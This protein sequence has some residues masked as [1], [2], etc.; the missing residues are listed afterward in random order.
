[1][2]VITAATG[3]TGRIIATRLLEA[4][5]KVR[6]AGRDGQKLLPF[7]EKGA[8]AAVGSLEDP[9]FVQQ[10]F[11]GAKAVYTLI[12]PDFTQND[13]RAYQNKIGRILADAIAENRV[14]FVVNM[15]S[16]GADLSE[17]VGP[18][19]GLHDQEQ[20]LNQLRGINVLH[21]R[22]AY[23][24]ENLF[25]NIDLIKSQ[26][27]NGSPIEPDVAFPMIATR[28]IGE[29]AAKRLLQLDFRGAGVQELLGERDLTMPEATAAVGKAIGKPDLPYVRFPY[30]AAHEAM[31]NM[32]LPRGIAD[33]FVELYS[34]LNEGRALGPMK[35]TAE[36]TTPT[37]IEAF[38][39]IFAA[40]Y[41]A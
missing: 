12:P 33:M 18:V 23:F 13:F 26:G 10:A 21:L 24:M 29:Y 16:L 39:E 20:R 2:Y 15:S 35:R 30:Q 25:L 6:V 1:M 4:G 17:G 5:Q 9:G 27:V 8:E 7:V 14:E 37:S 3:N 31:I 22:P 19:N 32:G 41:H 36:N 38:A 11:T 34:A 28:D 40:V